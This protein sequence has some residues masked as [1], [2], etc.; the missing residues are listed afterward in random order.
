MGADSAA[1]RPAEGGAT[2]ARIAADKKVASQ[3]ASAGAP[4]GPARS[5]VTDP[6]EEIAGTRALE[7]DAV[8]SKP[9]A[10]APASPDDPMDVDG[11]APSAEKAPKPGKLKGSK[12]KSR[13]QAKMG[14]DSADDEDSGADMD[15]EDNAPDPDDVKDAADPDGNQPKPKQT[16]KVIGDGFVH[17]AADVYV[18]SSARPG[19]GHIDLTFQLYD[20]EGEYYPF[21]NCDATG[22]YHPVKDAPLLRSK[23][24][25][26]R[27]LE[28]DG[29]TPEDAERY[30]AEFQAREFVESIP[31]EVVPREA[32]PRRKAAAN[33]AKYKDVSSDD[34][35]S[36]LM[37]AGETAPLKPG[38]EGYESEED[39]DKIEKILL[40]LEPGDIDAA[41]LETLG[42]D[43]AKAFADPW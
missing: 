2:A 1:A 26:Q 10:D 33:A 20:A 8:V 16:R 18:Q 5:D 24:A 30:A 22:H 3:L 14:D 12:G 25:V 43:D 6:A 28:R 4:K 42:S 38:D 23:I 13:M 37:E 40:A 39:E 7:A 21:K 32:P 19:T 27:Y 15:A 17:Y 36:D 29:M 41:E 31:I 35:M 11:D 34:D 9:T